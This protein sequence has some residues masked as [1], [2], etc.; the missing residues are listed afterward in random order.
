MLQQVSKVKDFRPRV[1]SIFVI[2]FSLI[3]CAPAARAQGSD[4]QSFKGEISGTVLVNT[5]NSPATQV[6]VGLRSHNQGIFRSVLT[7]YEGRFDARNLPSGVYDVVVE[8]AGYD[9]VTTR[10]KLSGAPLHLAIHLKATAPSNVP[11]LAATV[12]VRELQIPDKARNEFQLG[13]RSLEKDDNQ[14]G[15][16]HF[17]KA[18]SAF[19]GYYEAHY[20]AGVAELRLG[21][22]DA[23]MQAFQ[24]AIELSDGRYAPAAFGIGVILNG[25]G[26]S[27]E[28]E[29]IVRRGVEA[30]DSLPA[31]HV[32]LAILL[33]QQNQTEDAEASLRKALLRDAK[34][35]SAYLVL[36][37]VHM[38]RGDYNEQVGDLETYLKLQPNSPERTE[39]LEAH[40]AALRNLA[41]ARLQNGIPSVKTQ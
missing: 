17:N 19:A 35:A 23:A 8:E 2:S 25:L 34:F 38:R 1:R 37:D 33:L 13:L 14:G 22:T 26:K 40:E 11:R 7:D 41:Q 5:G 30:D 4:A 31:G 20:H 15:L 18:T 36:S 16:K 12:S 28:A 6:V 32:L 29:M 3:V 27:R 24:R 39:V 21:H 10:V 9:T